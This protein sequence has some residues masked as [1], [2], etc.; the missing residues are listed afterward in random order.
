ME[1][2]IQKLRLALPEARWTPRESWHA[3]LKFFGEVGDDRFEDLRRVAGK[4]SKAA[5]PFSTRLTEVGAFP[6]SRR[7][8]VL[9]VGL[10]DE[11]GHMSRLAWEM[12]RRFGKRGFRKEGRDLY[13]HLTLA[14]FRVPRPLAEPIAAS[15]PYEL[16]TE[17]FEISEIVLYRSHLSPKGA[18]YEASERFPL[19][20]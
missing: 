2:A 17:P 1:R 13:P 12:E 9:W 8:R 18:R 5:V 19:A 3:T 14:R 10:D 20:G 6:N 15:G 11:E 4:I 16:N 7:G